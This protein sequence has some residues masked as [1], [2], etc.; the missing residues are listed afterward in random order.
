MAR[1]LQSSLD[2]ADAPFVV[3]CAAIPENLLESTLFGHEKGR[4]QGQ[5]IAGGTANKR[6]VVRCYW[7]KFQKCH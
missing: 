6:R 7:T 5:H 2:E 1:F 4:W 3:D